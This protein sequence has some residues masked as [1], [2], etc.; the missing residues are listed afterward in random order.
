MEVQVEKPVPVTSRPQPHWPGDLVETV[1]KFSEL[2]RLIRQ[3]PSLTQEN[4]LHCRT[5]D[6]IQDEIATRHSDDVRDRIALGARMSH[7]PDLV[8][9]HVMIPIASQDSPVATIK[10]I[11]VATARKKREVFGHRVEHIPTGELRRCG[12][13][14]PEHGGSRDSRPRPRSPRPPAVCP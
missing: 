8:S 2:R 14:R 10:D 5:R 6:A 9:G 1:V 13:P 4:L 3:A 7:G 12:T 11:G